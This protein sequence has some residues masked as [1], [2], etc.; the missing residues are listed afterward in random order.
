MGISDRK[1]D[2]GNHAIQ[3]MAET[4]H[5]YSGV[6]ISDVVPIVHGLVKAEMEVYQQI[7]ET[8]VRSRFDDFT[9]SLE[10]Q[11]EA[12]VADK[13]DKFSEPGMQYAA[14][15]ATLGYIKSG[16]TEQK[17]SL[18][19]LLI[20]RITTEERSSEQLLIDEA[21]QILPKL[22]ST[23]VA[24]L[25]LM[26]YSKLKFIGKKSVLDSG[27]RKMNPIIDNVYNGRN[28]DLEY[29]VQSRCAFLVGI[30]QR[31]E[32]WWIQN[33][34]ENYPLLFS[35]IDNQDA[36]KRF[37]EKYGIN[38][39]ADKI[40]FPN[41]ITVQEIGNFLYCFD[42]L[43][44]NKIIP[45]FLTLDKYDELSPQLKPFAKEDI[46]SLLDSRTP[47]DDEEIISYY[48]N[49]NPRWIEAINLLEEKIS[50]YELTL[51]GKYIGVRQLTKLLDA[52]V[53]L[54]LLV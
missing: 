33:N 23:C 26:T 29:L 35:H 34:R 52:P 47:M 1:Q 16:E 14:K 51:V 25:T 3:V 13:V 10:S 20:E 28:I 21:I 15:E 9:K 41:N 50:H 37:L 22:S 12:K 45:S 39:H 24:L 31:E 27:I 6:Q 11:I 17:D 4:V 43:P 32:G 40:D 5:Y 38:R 42:L 44:E 30:V 7:A 8:K 48:S 49:V 19:D 54:D 53:P 18:I 46:F 2:A 36:A